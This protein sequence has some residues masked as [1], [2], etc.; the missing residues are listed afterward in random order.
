MLKYKNVGF[1][2]NPT[3]VDENLNMLID[4]IFEDKSIY[5]KCFF[6][7]EHGLRGDLQDTLIVKDY[8]DPYTGLPV[9]SVYGTRIAPTDE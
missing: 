6:A 7:P 2:T 8:I 4:V 3:G 1:L 9:Y 5:L